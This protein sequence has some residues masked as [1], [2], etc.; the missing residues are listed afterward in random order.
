[1]DSIELVRAGRLSDARTQLVSEVRTSPG[2][3]GKRTLLFQVHSLCGE[4]DK[5]ERDLDIIAAMDAGREAGAQAYMNLVHAEK[6][7]MEVFRNGR[8]PSF[9]PETP[10]YIETYYA[11]R[12]KLEEKNIEEAKR[13]F[14]EVDAAVPPVS[15]TLNGKKDFTGIKDTDSRLAWFLEAFA[16]ERYIWIPFESLREISI[17]PPKTLFDLIW[18]SAFMTLQG[19]LTLNCF[20]PVLYAESFMHEDE[21]I[22]LG[23]MTDWT[24]LGGPFSKG[25]GQHVFQI[26]EEEVALLEIREISFNP[27]VSEADNEKRD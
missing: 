13:L 18:V 11:A 17:T 9:L 3:A 25:A 1:M 2:D 20:L 6:E 23:R 14:D 15:G 4:W 27:T 16:H 21:R 10:P 19:G 24:P 22:K 12:Q 7:R 5:A 26:G 8:R